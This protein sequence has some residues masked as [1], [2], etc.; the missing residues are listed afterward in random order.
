MRGH[1]TRT[2]Y[3]VVGEG[4]VFEPDYLSGDSRG[5][6]VSSASAGKSAYPPFKFGRMFARSERLTTSGDWDATIKGL[7]RL[8]LCMNDPAKYCQGA[9]VK[10]PGD[11]LIPSGFTYL[12]QFIAHEITFDSAKDLPAAEPDPQNLRS[13]SIDLD[14]LYGAGPLDEQSRQLYEGGSSA[15]LKIGKTYPPDGL[16]MTFDNDLPRDRQTGRALIADERNDENLAVAQTHVALIRFHNRVVDTL[17]QSGYDADD[18][19]ECARKHV[20]RHFQW[21][22][23]HDYLPA[24]VDQGVLDCVLA[25]GLRWFKVA[26]KKDLFMPLEFSGAAFRVGHSMVRRAYQWN[27]FHS[28]DLGG[29]SGATLSQLF[30][31]TAFSG[32]IGKPPN[33]PALASEWVIDWSRFYQFPEFPPGRNY[34]RD[35]ARVNMARR[36]D[37]NF[38]FRLDLMSRFP[39]LDVADDKKSIT[40]RNLLRGFALGLPTGEEVARWIGETPLR[41][42]EVAGGP[43]EELLGAP[44]F[45]GKTPLW[46]YILKEAELNGGSRLGRVGSRIVAET[47]V[48]LISHS[49]YSVLDAPRWYPKYTRRGAPGT[50]SARFGMVD[51]LD[52]AG[53][54]NPIEGQ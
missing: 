36:I 7:I 48:G 32:L 38:D 42:E 34:K 5:C 37:T 11:S 28:T 4:A 41:H 15:R 30:S 27:L 17:R 10:A 19:F 6:P 39:H 16:A 40:V 24:I 54:V 33:R 9:Q 26:R 23:L 35:P 12:G 13:P 8:G 25:H 50:E 18:L 2:A 22:V 47:L 1:G 14:S 20:V 43:H 3:H 49:R 21:I 31:Q 46:Y 45:K 44:V 29:L 53:V 51:L 52:F